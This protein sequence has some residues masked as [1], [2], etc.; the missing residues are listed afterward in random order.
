M[1]TVNMHE[2]KS[3]L[4]KLVM[5][6]LHGEDVVLCTNGQPRVRLT[7]IPTNPAERDLTPDPALMPT[8][9]QGY[10]PAE[11]LGADEFPDD[12]P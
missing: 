4:S 5:E 7:P 1:I 12:A 2:A 10:D 3:Q 8:L 11:P 9:A 6:A